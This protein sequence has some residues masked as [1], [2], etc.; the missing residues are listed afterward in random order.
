MSVRYSFQKKA[1]SRDSSVPILLQPLYK[2]VLNVFYFPAT[3]KWKG[4]VV[5]F[6]VLLLFFVCF[7][8]FL[9]CLFKKNVRN[10]VVLF[11]LFIYFI[12]TWVP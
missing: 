10:F 7:V 2:S 6:V 1:H 11:Y 12:D 4:R 5:F 8:C 3:M 9:V